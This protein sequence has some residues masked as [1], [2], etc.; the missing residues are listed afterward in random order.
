MNYNIQYSFSSDFLERYYVRIKRGGI[1]SF[2][3]GERLCLCDGVWSA[4]LSP[5]T[6]LGSAESV[7][8]DSCHFLARSPPLSVVLCNRPS[9][10]WPQDRVVQCWGRC[11]VKYWHEHLVNKPEQCPGLAKVNG[12]ALCCTASET[13]VAC[14][15]IRVITHTSL[16]SFLQ[17]MSNTTSSGQPIPARPGDRLGDQEDLSSTPGGS[18]I[19]YERSF[20]I[21]MR[22]CP[23]ARTPPRNIQ[24]IPSGLW[25]NNRAVSGAWGGERGEDHEEWLMASL[26]VRSEWEWA[27]E[28]WIYNNVLRT[29][30][31]DFNRTDSFWLKIH[32]E[33]LNNFQPPP[34]D[35]IGIILW[36]FNLSDLVINNLRSIIEMISGTKGLKPA[37]IDIKKVTLRAIFITVN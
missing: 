15:T 32:S 35:W 29:K 14:Y 11:D 10:P 30:P 6:Q 17:R 27:G 23:L 9:P 26:S 24:N 33:D 16:L 19:V 4:D 7:N 8:K 31:N 36:I 12:V 1:Q 28:K 21:N 18:K 34:R 2:M 3:S 37:L 20:L 13:Q 25:S 22:N 5:H